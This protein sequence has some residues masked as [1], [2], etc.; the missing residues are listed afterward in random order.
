MKEGVRKGREG[1][2]E[3]GEKKIIGKKKKRKAMTT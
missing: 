1:W 3:E 2:R